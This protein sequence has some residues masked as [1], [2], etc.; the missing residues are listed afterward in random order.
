MY[1]VIYLWKVKPEKRAEHD[2]VMTEVLRAERERCPEV[3]LNLTMGPAADGTV[4]EVQVYRDAETCNGGFSARVKR[5]DAEL[6]RLWDLFGDL[7]QPDGFTTH[8]FESMDFLNESFARA[9]AG[10]GSA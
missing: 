5:E 6:Q 8:R 9:A 4:A 1:G 7:C 3:L 2:R 10:L